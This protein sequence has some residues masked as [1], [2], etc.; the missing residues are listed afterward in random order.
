MPEV[1]ITQL[2]GGNLVEAFRW[3]HHTLLSPVILHA[4]LTAK[5][6]AIHFVPNN[7]SR[8]RARN[9]RSEGGL[10]FLSFFLKR[11]KENKPE[12]ARVD[13]SQ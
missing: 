4:A 3:Y 10:F 11:T 6:T 7:S 8:P 9:K 13:H 12:V 5:L 1:S 2:A